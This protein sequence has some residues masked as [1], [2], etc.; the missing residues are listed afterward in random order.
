MEGLCGGPGPGMG[1][2]AFVEAG[3]EGKA[4][5]SPEESCG[6]CGPPVGV[7]RVR[8]LRRHP[9]TRVGVSRMVLP[10]LDGEGDQAWPLPTRNHRWPMW[11]YSGLWGLLGKVEPSASPL[12]DLPPFLVGDQPGTA[13]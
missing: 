9:Q 11:G 2:R 12:G 7:T 13:A 10:R 1:P 3:R 8:T 6:L 5:L 4:R